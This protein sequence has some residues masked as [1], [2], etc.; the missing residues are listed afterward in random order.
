MKVQKLATRNEKKKT[1]NKSLDNNVMDSFI[2]IQRIEI[3]QVSNSKLKKE[4]IKKK[5]SSSYHI[6]NNNLQNLRSKKTPVY[7]S[8]KTHKN[9]KP[10][11]IIKKSID[12]SQ[13][14]RV[15]YSMSNRKKRLSEPIEKIKRTSNIVHLN[16]KTK[17]KCKKNIIN[18]FMI[19]KNY[20][21]QKKNNNEKNQRIADIFKIESQNFN[22]K[23]KE[24]YFDPIFWSVNENNKTKFKLKEKKNTPQINLSNTNLKNYL[25]PKKFNKQNSMNKHIKL[26]NNNQFSNF[27]LFLSKSFYFDKWIKSIQLISSFYKN[28]TRNKLLFQNKYYMTYLVSKKINNENYVVKQIKLKDLSN[29]KILKKIKVNFKNF[30][31]YFII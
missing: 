30:Y 10:N 3:K 8:L 6:E 17:R 28:Y 7:A 23:M 13:I 11:L 25:K 16:N 15:N 22:L 12:L 26:L 19:K 20:K 1:Q 4:D 9:T 27:S 24:F 14:I 18:C 2:K 29:R 31:D 5:Q 21:K